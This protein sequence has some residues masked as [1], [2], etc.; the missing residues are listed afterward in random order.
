VDE[1]RRALSSAELA[2]E[3]YRKKLV[4]GA[5]VHAL[6]TDRWVRADFEVDKH[7]LTLECDGL[8]TRLANQSNW[9][10]H[11]RRNV[12]AP[13]ENAYRL[14][15][16]LFTPSGSLVALEIDRATGAITVIDVETFL[17]AGRV[18]Q[19]DLVQ[20]QND[21]GV[22]MGIGYALMENAPI[23]DDGPGGG[24]WNLHRY[25]VPQAKDVPM[26]NIKLTVLGTDEPTAK[27]IAEAVLCPI[28]AA[29][30]NAV[31][32]ATGHRPRALPITPDWVRQV[33]S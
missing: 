2:E 20:G 33:L 11:D 31:A 4:S 28:P 13:A 25:R 16:S 21:G 24:Q 7:V 32:H 9:R 10:M 3:I 14:G 17:D 12:V 1:G 19:A 30:A 18:I 5:T 26:T 27:G 8:S 6:H 29:I 22:A 15:R 23:G